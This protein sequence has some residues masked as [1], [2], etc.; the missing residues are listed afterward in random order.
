MTAILAGVAM[1][2]KKLDDRLHTIIES[3]I[4]PSKLANSEFKNTF[5][6]LLETLGLGRASMKSRITVFDDNVEHSEPLNFKFRFSDGKTES[7]SY[8]PLQNFLSQRGIHALIVGEGEGLPDR[9]LYYEEIWQLKKNI[10]V[11]SADLRKTGDEPIF[12]YIITG[13]TDLV[14]VY[15]PTWPI[16]KQN[17]RYY[18]EIKTVEGFREEDSLREAAAQ[19][20]GGNA[21]NGFHSPPVLLSNLFKNHYLLYFTLEGDPRLLLAYKLNV[22]KMPSFG[23]AL[24]MVESMTMERH[25]Y[26]RNMGCKPTPPSSP[27]R[28]CESESDVA[29]DEFE[30]VHIEEVVLDAAGE[31]LE[32]RFD[33]EDEAEAVGKSMV[34]PASALEN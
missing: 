11:S 10:S 32:D 9:N 12:K 30:N 5:Y 7:S 3:R 19:L 34:P 1:L 25:C 13:R 14:C 4:T 24:A 22:L 16:G 33:A 17:N 6:D 21:A 8:M 28:N 20:I 29:A 18:I 2:Q 27:P 26:T 31:R 23:A 15:N